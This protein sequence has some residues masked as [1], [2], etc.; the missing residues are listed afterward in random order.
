MLGVFQEVAIKISDRPVGELATFDLMYQGIRSTLKSGIQSSILMAERQLADGSEDK[1]FAVRLLK[2]LFLVKYVKEF[3]ATV[4][5][6]CVLMTGSFEADISRLGDRVQEALSLLEQ[7]TYIQRNGDLYEYLTDEEKDIEEEIKSTEVE[8]SVVVKTLETLIFEFVIKGS[9]IRYSE[10]KQDYSFS[11]K[12]DGQLAGREHELAINV[13]TP[14]NDN[15]ENEALLKMQSLG[16]DE[17]RVVMPPDDRLMRDLSMYVRT[18]KYRQQKYVFGAAG[19]D[20]A[21]FGG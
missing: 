20:S 12:L 8:H 15:S 19:S 1:D 7:Q 9:K 2:T 4:R 18:E 21:N 14:F 6:L 10:N 16:L 17:L 3:K 13:I 5:N 11:R